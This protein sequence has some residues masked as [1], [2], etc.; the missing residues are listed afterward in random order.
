MYHIKVEDLTNAQLIAY[1]KNNPFRNSVSTMGEWD[2]Q[3][4]AKAIQ[5]EIDRRKS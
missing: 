4:F 3:S 2:R 5:K 1:R